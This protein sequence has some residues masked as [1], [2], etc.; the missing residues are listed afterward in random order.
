MV[1]LAVY[2]IVILHG[3]FRSC[4]RPWAAN[5][6]LPRFSYGARVGGHL[7]L[8]QCHLRKVQMMQV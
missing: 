5:S 7:G 6:E 2:I 1:F 4:S 3:I 8:P